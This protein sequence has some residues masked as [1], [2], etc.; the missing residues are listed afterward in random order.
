VDRPREWAGRDGPEVVFE[1][2]GV[3]SLVQ[4]SLDLVAHGGRVVVVGLSGSPTEIRVGQLPLKEV[5]LLG[6][7]CCGADDFAAAVDLVARRRDAAATLVTHEFGFEQT[8]EAIAYAIAHP[9]EVMKAV[10]LLDGS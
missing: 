4:T 5:D 8:P 1:A 10:V 7:S 3:P 9:A 2:T 6:T